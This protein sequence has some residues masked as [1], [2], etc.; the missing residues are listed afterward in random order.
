[1]KDDFLIIGVGVKNPSLMK[2]YH[3]RFVSFLKSRYNAH[4]TSIVKTEI[5]IMPQITPE[6]PFYPGKG[7][8]LFAGEAANLLNPMGEGISCAFASGHAA[9]ESVKFYEN[10]DDLLNCYKNKLKGEI[11]YLI[12]QWKFLGRISSKFNF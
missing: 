5:G 12:R 1:V 3:S 8:V 10:P 11:E 4:I 9:A 7:R 2:K 6:F